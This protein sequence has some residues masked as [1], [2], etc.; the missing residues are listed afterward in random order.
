M[1]VV[2]AHRLRS[3]QK[4]PEARRQ[5]LDGRCQRL[6]LHARQMVGKAHSQCKILPANLPWQRIYRGSRDDVRTDG[7]EPMKK[8][9]AGG[10]ALPAPFLSSVMQI[11]PQ[12]IDYNGHLNMA[13]Y[14]VMFDRALDEFWLQLGID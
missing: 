6:R 2:L 10:D 11:E 1:A 7:I 12:W 9:A 14:N 13:Y 8:F 5:C 3:D 4:V